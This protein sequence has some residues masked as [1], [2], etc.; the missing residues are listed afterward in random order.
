MRLSELLHSDVVTTDGQALGR[1]KDAKLVQD[2]PLVGAFGASLRVEGF[3]VG[4]GA[5]GIRLGFDRDSVRG[6]WPLKALF[7]WLQRRA[8][9]FT[10]DQVRSCEE[11]RVV[12]NAAS[13]RRMTR[14]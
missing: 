5:L 12:V 3:C 9:Y 10:W 1:I 13:D 14:E 2:G 8:A 7:M 11:G 4:G 6:P